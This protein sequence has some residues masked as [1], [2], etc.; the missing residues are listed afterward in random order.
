MIPLIEQHRTEL[1]R[2]CREFNVRRLDLFGSAVNGRFEDS[3]SDLDFIVSFGDTTTSGYA[4]RYLNFAQALEQMFRRKVDL[5]TERS[6]RNPF[7]RHALE[8][9][10]EPVYDHRS[11]EAAA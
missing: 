5:V 8:S 6:I 3:S 11:E 4:D 7:F 2:L 1:N 9:A 10:R